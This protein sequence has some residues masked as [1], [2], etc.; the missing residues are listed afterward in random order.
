MV[1]LDKEKV[2]FRRAF[3]DQIPAM[4]IALVLGGLT[5][6]LAFLGLL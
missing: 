1:F 4:A 6:L 2:M 5:T 3:I